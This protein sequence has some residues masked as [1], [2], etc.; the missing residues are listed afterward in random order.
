MSSVGMIGW[1]TA[2]ASP[3]PGPPAA[4]KRSSGKASMTRPVGHFPI[5]MSI[6]LEGAKMTIRMVTADAIKTAAVDQYIDAPRGLAIKTT[7]ADR[8]L[9]QARHKPPT[10]SVGG[11]QERK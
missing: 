4:N 8:L 2:I 7:V 3:Q 5:P 11:E 9:T 10:K 1:P 6:S